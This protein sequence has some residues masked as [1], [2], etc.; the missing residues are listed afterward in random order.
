[1][2]FRTSVAS[3]VALRMTK[4]LE[5]ID[6]LMSEIESKPLRMTEAAPSLFETLI[7]TDACGKPSR[8]LI[9]TP[10]PVQGHESWRSGLTARIYSASY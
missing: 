1:M 3:N 6:R 10:P 5:S 9:W 4:I 8:M 2:C 7:K